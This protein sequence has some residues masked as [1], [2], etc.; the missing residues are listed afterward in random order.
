MCDVPGFQVTVVS[1][2]LLGFCTN[3][4]SRFPQK[5]TWVTRFLGLSGFFV[6]FR[7]FSCFPGHMTTGNLNVKILML[8]H[9]A[10][11]VV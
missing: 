9:R 6:F 4:L 11:Q 5:S 7:V 8:T 10:T 3:F 1:I 2:G